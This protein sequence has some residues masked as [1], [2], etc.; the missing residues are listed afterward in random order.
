MPVP[1]RGAAAP[2]PRAFAGPGEPRCRDEIAAHAARH[3]L[4]D[5]L[6]RQACDGSALLRHYFGASE[7]MGPRP[8]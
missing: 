5:A 3:G 2:D 6:V 4:D 1:D 8:A 7:T